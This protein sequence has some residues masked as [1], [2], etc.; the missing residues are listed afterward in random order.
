M[1]ISTQVF[2]KIPHDLHW[3]RL[4]SHEPSAISHSRTEARCMFDLLTRTWGIR[5]LY[6]GKLEKQAQA[7]LCVST[8]VLTGWKFQLWLNRNRR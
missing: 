4:V 6:S 3:L 5:G 8:S 2:V 1:S 7:M